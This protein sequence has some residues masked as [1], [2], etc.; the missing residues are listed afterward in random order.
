[1]SAPKD[2]PFDGALLGLKRGARMTRETWGRP[3]PWVALMRQPGRMRL[4]RPLPTQ[5]APQHYEDRIAADD[6]QVDSFFVQHTIS[7]GY[8]VWTPSTMD[9]LANDWKEYQG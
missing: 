3:A 1:M 8:V 6:I 4:Y 5:W 9:I 7:G 2:M